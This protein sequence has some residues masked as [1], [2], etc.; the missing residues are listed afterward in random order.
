MFHSDRRESVKRY[1][2]YGFGLPIEVEACCPEHAEL[3]VYLD[4]PSVADVDVS[5]IH[6]RLADA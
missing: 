5:N 2:V 4:L 3:L 6:T 1:K